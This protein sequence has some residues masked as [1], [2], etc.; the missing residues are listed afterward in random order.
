[1]GFQAD[2]SERD[3]SCGKHC[4]S[5]TFVN[6]AGADS[7]AAVAGGAPALNNWLQVCEAGAGLHGTLSSANVSLGSDSI[8]E[9]DDLLD[10]IL[11]SQNAAATGIAPL[12]WT[13]LGGVLALPGSAANDP[14]AFDPTCFDQTDYLVAVNPNGSDSWWVGWT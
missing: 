7:E 12:D 1:M 9:G 13:A 4:R 14:L 8:V 3:R 2:S 11:S 10:G 6:V 5:A